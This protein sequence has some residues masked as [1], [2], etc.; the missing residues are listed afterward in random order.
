MTKRIGG[1]QGRDDRRKEE[2][3]KRGKDVYARVMRLLDEHGMSLS[4]AARQCDTNPSTF[5]NWKDGGAPNLITLESLSRVLGTPVS[6]IIGEDSR[7]SALP[8]PIIR[9]E[10]KDWLATTDDE[11]TREERAMLASIAIPAER[12]IN[13]LFYSLVL[14]MY[15]ELTKT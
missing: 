11:V 5:H 7:D 14:A 12:T 6:T 9:Q 8:R 1:A 15:R 3:E 4:A 2:R 13:P 10:L